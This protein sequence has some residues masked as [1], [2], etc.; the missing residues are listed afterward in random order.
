M[1]CYYLSSCHPQSEQY[2]VDHCRGGLDQKLGRIEGGG[3]L[4]DANPHAVTQNLCQLV[5]KVH[6]YLSTETLFTDG[7][8]PVYVCFVPSVRLRKN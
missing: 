1:D 8:I 4:E 3:G 5:F 2:D 6:E 7:P